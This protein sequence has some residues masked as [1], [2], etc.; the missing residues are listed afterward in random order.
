MTNRPTLEQVIDLL[1]LQPLPREGG[2]YRQT[3]VSPQQVSAPGTGVLK[4]CGTA[5]Y[6]L[7]TKQP[8]SFSALHR[9]PTDEIW[10]FYLGDALEMTLLYPDGTVRHV[11]LGQD[12][13]AGQQPQ[14]VV[15]AGVWQGTHLSGGGEYGLA[16]TT[17]APGFT[18]D[19]LEI[20]DRENLLQQFPCARQQILALTRAAG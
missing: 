12:I 18:A 10:H 15:P 2:L 3:W 14:F 20:G 13:R 17:M 9:L 16:G 1:D 4:P 6:Y 5:I 19:D 11:L 7:L 8:G